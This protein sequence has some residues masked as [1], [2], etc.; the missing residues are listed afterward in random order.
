MKKNR[1]ARLKEERERRGAA[2]RK[3][4]REREEFA[5]RCKD[6]YSPEGGE[7]ANFIDGLTPRGFD[8]AGRKTSFVERGKCVF[9]GGRPSVRISSRRKPDRLSE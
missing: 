4:K 2:F 6:G 8:K 3:W 7:L 1:L 5:Q 9:V